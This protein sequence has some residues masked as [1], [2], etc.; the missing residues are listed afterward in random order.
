MTGS[1]Q[2]ASP[3]AVDWAF[4]KATGARLVPA[5]PQVSAAEAAEVVASVREAA[6]SAEIIP[7]MRRFFDVE[8]V[9]MGMS[10]SFEVLLDIVHNFDPDDD[11]NNALIDG[12]MRL[13]KEAER[14]GEAEPL[15]AC[16]LARHKAVP[17]A[18]PA[19]TAVPPLDLDAFRGIEGWMADE[20]ADPKRAG[21]I[22][23]VLRGTPED[24]KRYKAITPI[25]S[26][27]TAFLGAAS[28]GR[29]P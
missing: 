7:V 8:V 14:T 16:L 25:E 2:Q 5:G 22:L 12:I 26:A 6:R 4:A 23:E 13:E 15:F 19:P 11:G 1:T 18:K 3:R 17:S 9:P 10:L 28:E 29:L 20:A 27:L 24:V 21:R